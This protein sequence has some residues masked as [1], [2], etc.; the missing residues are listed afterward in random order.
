MGS[1][2][3]SDG[4]LDAS[5]K[6]Q[7]LTSI[8]SNPSDDS[9]AHFSSTRVVRVR[10]IIVQQQLLRDYKVETPCVCALHFSVKRNREEYAVAQ[11]WV[12]AK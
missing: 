5:R 9:S 1:S 6:R 8:G 10:C 7:C 2:S 3:P 12:G 4:G 11:G